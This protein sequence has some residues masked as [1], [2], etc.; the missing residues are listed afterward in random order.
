MFKKFNIQKFLDKKP[1]SDNSFTT[2][3]EIKQSNI[4][5]GK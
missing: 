5:K 2:M 4:Q 1:P 3:Q